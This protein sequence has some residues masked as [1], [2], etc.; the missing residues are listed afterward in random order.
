MTALPIDYATGR[1]L[2]VEQM[3][4]IAEITSADSTVR[5]MK[6]ENIVASILDIMD[7]PQE[8]FANFKTPGIK[9]I[10]GLKK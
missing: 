8:K 3:T 6:P 10:P 5:M 1:A 4:D 2:R 9:K 7:I